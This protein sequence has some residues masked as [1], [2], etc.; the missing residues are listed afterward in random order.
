MKV[1][2]MIINLA[3]LVAIA[4][5][6]AG[7]SAAVMAFVGATDL[8]NYKL[9]FNLASIA[10]FVSAP[11]WLTPQMFGEEYAEAGAELPCGSTFSD[12]RSFLC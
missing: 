12:S 9:I 8:D 6:I 1:K 3:S 2:T 4:S 10:W 7:L 11:Y 5:L